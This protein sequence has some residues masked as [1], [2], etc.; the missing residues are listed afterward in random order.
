MV[1]Y[2]LFFPRY[3]GGFV[4]IFTALYYLTDH[5][6]DIRL[7][8][9]VYVGFYLLYLALVFRI[10]RKTAKVYLPLST[11]ITRVQYKSPTVHRTELSTIHTKYNT[12]YTIHYSLFFLTG[13]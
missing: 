6:A 12:Q 3:P 5:G 11:N 2:S 13:P 7:A 9:Y 1:V 10:Y 4:Y 8:Q